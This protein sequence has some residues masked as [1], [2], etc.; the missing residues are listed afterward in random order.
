MQRRF[1]TGQMSKARQT[2]SDD[3]ENYFLVFEEYSYLSKTLNS[4]CK[5]LISRAAD[6]VETIFTIMPTQW[7]VGD[8][9]CYK[10]WFHKK[11]FYDKKIKEL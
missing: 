1:A 9:R 5:P 7:R 10:R 4:T 11:H 8:H 2:D 3:P 6:T